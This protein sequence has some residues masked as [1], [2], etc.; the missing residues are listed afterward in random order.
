M[1]RRPRSLADRPQ[2][3][4]TLLLTWTCWSVA[5]IG[6]SVPARRAFF[7]PVSAVP[8]L[9]Q[10][11]SSHATRPIFAYALAAGWPTPNS[12]VRL[13]AAVLG[14]LCAFSF[15]LLAAVLPPRTARRVFVVALAAVAVAAL[16]AVCLDVASIV[17]TQGECD[18]EDC[19]TLVPQGVRESGN[20]CKCSV[21]V[22][23]WFTVFVDLVLFA[24]ASLCLFLTAYPMI[25][26]RGVD[27]SRTLS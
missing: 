2:T 13:V 6:P 25:K 15:A 12:A 10:E 18:R 5:V 14:V 20:T 1:P 8:D 17:K 7:R 21:D 26:R 16:V 4:A 3:C 19:V 9:I 27:P 22:A 11:A 23:F 24:S